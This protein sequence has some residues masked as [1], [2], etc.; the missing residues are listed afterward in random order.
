MDVSKTCQFCT[1][2][3]RNQEFV[4]FELGTFTNVHV[5]FKISKHSDI[6]M[7]TFRGEARLDDFDST[8]I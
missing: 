6:R 3:R 5:D 4:Q 2:V 7:F 1:T 8:S